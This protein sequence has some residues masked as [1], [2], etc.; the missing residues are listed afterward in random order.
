[1]SQND[2]KPLSK[3]ATEAKVIEQLTKFSKIV[4][5]LGADPIFA[6]AV[7]AAPDSQTNGRNFA[8]I[9]LDDAMEAFQLMSYA[10]M[11]SEARDDISDLPLEAYRVLLEGRKRTQVTLA[12]AQRNLEKNIRDKEFLGTFDSP[13]PPT[14][15]TI[16]STKTPTQLTDRIVD[17]MSREWEA[18]IANI[19]ILFELRNHAAAIDITLE[20]IDTMNDAFS[21]HY[22]E[23]LGKT[24]KKGTTT[25]KKTAAN[26]NAK[27]KDSGMDPQLEKYLEIFGEDV[28]ST[29]KNAADLDVIGRDD[30]VN[31]TLA[32]LIRDGASYALSVGKKG[33][34]K[35]AV[36]QKLAQKIASGKVP[37]ELKNARIIR[38][39]LREMRAESGSMQKA[40]E[41]LGEVSMLDQFVNRL[42]TILSKT[43]EYNAQGGPQIIL[44]IDEL[45]EI[46]GGHPITSQT[47]RDLLAAKIG[48]TPG[49]RIIGEIS[50]SDRLS[51]NKDMPDVMDQFQ[52]TEVKPLSDEQTLAVLQKASAKLTTATGVAIG[53]ELLEQ[54]ISLSKQR[55]PGIAQPK[56]SLDVLNA[57]VAFAKTNN[58]KTL[59]LD[60]LAEVIS[61]KA[62]IPKEM[63][64][65]N[66]DDRMQ[67]LDTRLPQIVLGQPAIKQIATSLKVANAGL[68]NPNKP[69]G[70]FLL[71]GPTGTG[72]TE[73]GKALS[74]ELGV[75][76]IRIDMANFQDQH[77]KAKLIGSPPGYVG[78]NDTPALQ[79]VANSPYCVLVLDEI[80]KA[81][82][83]VFNTLL[84][85]MN[86]GE[87]QL[88]NGATVDFRNCVILMTSNL[89]AKEAQA[90]RKKGVAGI[91]VAGKDDA[92]NRGSEAMRKAVE[93][94]LP[95][96]F[97]GRLTDTLEYIPLTQDVVRGIAMQQIEKVSQSLKNKN[98]NLRIELTPQAVDELLGLGFDPDYG[99]RPMEKAV[100]KY[101]SLPISSW[102]IDNARSVTE[103]T[104][105]LVKKIKDTFDFELRKAPSVS[106]PAPG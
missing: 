98:K 48:N 26:G 46:S 88:M 56:A 76:M 3:E 42:N 105:I 89:G 69:L 102:F 11:V 80:E 90:A 53:T 58:D 60:H 99:A 25:N 52:E 72:K 91:G 66:R 62:K 73:T 19:G 23:N 101:I 61:R 55:I 85:V 103:P 7:K 31:S 36:T 9:V 5:S 10:T 71:I 41:E 59:V 95:P 83:D 32:A 92:V 20:L 77:A 100:N 84:S 63:I 35:S 12:E 97:I 49:L 78:Y 82:S 74:K 106:A 93:D 21:K 57:A 2:K 51:L 28:T 38:L 54:A 8:Q 34:G 39:K 13:Q 16:L 15:L 18:V 14:F 81:H 65:T 86:E 79:Q 24:P 64:N 33:A 68:S 45:A 44:N 37:D 104:T 70:S 29:V 75:P 22:A 96:E 17:T 6:G 87:I 4:T 43:A 27:Q 47:I 67:S 30:E 94:K 50:D 1:M 40:N